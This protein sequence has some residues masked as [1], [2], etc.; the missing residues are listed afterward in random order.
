LPEQLNEHLKME[1]G[2]LYFFSFVETISA[3]ASLPLNSLSLHSIACTD[4]FVLTQGLNYLPS[5]WRA[6]LPKDFI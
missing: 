6:S 2:C 1:W 4:F 3:S 5:T